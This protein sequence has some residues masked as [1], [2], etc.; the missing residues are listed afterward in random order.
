[1]KV[2]DNMEVCGITKYKRRNLLRKDN[3]VERF[4]DSEER[5][6][7]IAVNGSHSWT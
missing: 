6:V 2:I 5:E 3:A 1:M 7:A 4:K